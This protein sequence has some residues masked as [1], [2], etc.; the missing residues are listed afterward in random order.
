MFEALGRGFDMFLRFGGYNDEGC[1]D[2][3][4]KTG[5]K[6][7]EIISPSASLMNEVGKIGIHPKLSSSDPSEY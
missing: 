7:V 6:V 1:I 2:E 3:I 5:L 4:W